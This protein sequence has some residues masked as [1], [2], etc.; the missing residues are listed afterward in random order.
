MNIR[1]DLIH[2]VRVLRRAPGLSLAVIATL[3]LGIAVN[4]SIFSVVYGV[5]LRPLPYAQPDR[6]VTVWVS[7]PREGIEKD[8]T[9]YPNLLAWRERSHSFSRLVSARTT[10]MN[11][12]TSGDPEEVRG[13]TVTEGF[14]EMMG[15]PAERGRT[16]SSAEESPDGPL[17]VVISHELW[18]TRFGSDPG[19][20]VRS[21][22]LNGASYPVV[23]VMPAGFAVERFWIT[24][25]FTGA[26][27]RLRDSWGALWLPV[28]GRLATGVSIEAAQAEMTAVARRIEEEQPGNAGMGVLLEPFRDSVVGDARSGLLVLLGSVVLVLM[29]A[30]ANIANL[31]LARGTGRRREMAVRVA[32]GAPRSRLIRQVLTESLVLAAVGGACGL[33]LATWGTDLLVAIAPADLPRLDQIRIDAPVLLFVLGVALLAGLLFGSAPAWQ[34]G[35]R[36]QSRFLA[37]G[38]RGDIGSSDRLRP[39]L[40]VA[41]FALAV[42]LLSAAGLLMRSFANL[43][44][45]DPGFEQDG[46]LSVSIN[47]PARKYAD[48]AAV[49]RFFD[50]LVADVQNEP[51][52]EAAGLISNL[53]ISRLPQSAPVFVEGSEIPENERELPVAYDAISPELPGTLGLRLQSGREFTSADGP[54]S[55]TVAI[56]NEAFVRR[57]VPR[58]DALGRRFAFGTAAPADPANWITIVGVSRDTRR[59]GLDQADRPSAF[60]PFAQYTPN[61]M[62]MLV[63][64]AGDPLALTTQVREAVRRIDPE[65]PLANVR[66]LDQLIAQSVESR[67]FIMLLLA[68]FAAC[69]TVL[70]AVGIYGVMAY[71]VGRRTREIGVRMALGARA[72]QVLSLVIGQALRHAGLG[73]LAGIVIALLFG[74]LLQNQLFGIGAHDPLTLAGVAVLL[75]GVALLASWLPARRAAHIHPLE[76]LR[77]D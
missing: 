58:G 49:R 35:H 72:G 65:Q 48:E 45:V 33:A 41:Q 15:V 24:Q 55:G 73:L 21:I 38:G 5:L 18:S 61:R 66:T 39:A 53:F 23:G 11:L 70:A 47:L 40:V 44:S 46:V 25:K 19:I 77:D 36:D 30:C 27:A 52:V 76:A 34:V 60:L 6:L 54:A 9:S 17:A 4:S 16:F 13:S 63:R 3:A 2:A 1:N 43:Q 7:N 59:S 57:Y 14:F 22:E 12:T 20:L 31:L 10:T 8:I 71:A 64:T 67:R 75:A 50:G 26:N 37:E 74:R 28:M 56:V 29:I 69:A 68:L 62:T 32:L 42:A 51:R